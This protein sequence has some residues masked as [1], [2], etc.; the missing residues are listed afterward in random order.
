MPMQPDCGDPL[1]QIALPPGSAIRPSPCPGLHRIVQAKDGGICRIKLA[2]GRLPASHA[3]SI[4]R[5]ALR[6]ADGVIEATNRANLQI[7]GIHAGAEQALVSE[8]LAAGLG[9]GMPGADDVR[10]LMV[11]P[12]AGLDPQALLD[13]SPLAAQILSSLENNPQLHL[14]SPKFALLLD[15]GERMAMLEH[16]HDIWLS[17]MHLNGQIGYAFG[18]A[19]CPPQL[20]TDPPALAVVPEA[21]AHALVLALLEL[22]LE[23][24]SPGQTHMRHLL[25]SYPASELL[26]RLRQRLGE[27][28]PSAPKWRRPPPL[29]KVHIGA[30]P[31]R[32]SGLLHIGAV[33]PLGRLDAAQLLGLAELSRR[34]GDGHLRLTPWQSL[35]LPNIPV[36]NKQAVCQQLQ[37]LGL[38]LDAN[39]PLT[40]IIACTGSNGCAKALAD[41]KGDAQRLIRGLVAGRLPEA[42]HLSGCKRSCAAARRLPLTLLAVAEGRYDLFARRPGCVDFGAPLARHLSVDEASELLTSLAD[43]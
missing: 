20:E 8:L 19:G 40:R 10:N 12:S 22:F 2:C 7:R 36:A 21:K 33:P 16:P 15:G 29:G 42:V 3:Q 27:E 18:I 1:K 5:A 23:L 9:Q 43:I 28:L 6:H 11:S 39:A 17:A 38:L 31:Q 26:Q 14:L 25:Q 37:E 13:V 24:A 32:Q 35:L 30:A 4:A 34:L 41:T